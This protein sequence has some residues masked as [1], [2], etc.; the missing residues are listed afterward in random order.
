MTKFETSELK[1]IGI[2]FMLCHHCFNSE[3]LDYIPVISIGGIGLCNILQS[4]TNPVYIFLI[5]SGYGIYMSF[6]NNRLH[7][8]WG[9]E[10]HRVFKLYLKYWIVLLIFAIGLGSFVCPNVYPG[11]IKTIFYNFSGYNPNRYDSAAWFLLPWCVLIIF[12]PYMLKIL[13]KYPKHTMAIS[14]LLW[15]FTI[16]IKRYLGV[17]SEWALYLALC[18]VSFIFPFLLGSIMAKYE[19]F[20]QF[21]EIFGRKKILWSSVFLLLIIVRYYISL[22][23]ILFVISVLL[24]YFVIKKPQLVSSVLNELG[25]KSASMWLIHQFYCKYI[26]NDYLYSLKYSLLIYIVLVLV[27]YLSACAID[28]LYNKLILSF[29]YGSKKLRKA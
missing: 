7:G 11:D 3:A 28:F 5:L 2:L 15:V 1:G 26:F 4:L 25:S 21:K 13:E 6:K 16:C 19:I 24:F 12:C 23:H 10:F 22:T 9:G 8:S 17:Y 20:E 14:M 27:S 18:T 29:G